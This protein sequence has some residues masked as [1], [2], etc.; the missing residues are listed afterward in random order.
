MQYFYLPIHGKQKT[1]I[2]VAKL[3]S[4][5]DTACWIEEAGEV[6]AWQIHQLKIRENNLQFFDNSR[7]EAKEDQNPE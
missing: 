2:M 7:K 3:Q 5:Q 1:I 6:T 4:L